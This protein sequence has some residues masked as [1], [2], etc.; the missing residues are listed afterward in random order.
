[1]PP[2]SQTTRNPQPSAGRNKPT[3]KKLSR[4]FASAVG[5]PESIIWG[6]VNQSIT[7]STSNKRQQQTHHERLQMSIASSK[8]HYESPRAQKNINL[9]PETVLQARNQYPTN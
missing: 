3:Y 9:T 2:H 5:K 6:R 4:N 7:L 8:M 1:V